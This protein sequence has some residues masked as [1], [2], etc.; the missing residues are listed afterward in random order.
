MPFKN[1]TILVT[2]GTG[3]FGQAFVRK[4]LRDCSPK[5]VIVFSRDEMKQWEM[6]KAFGN[7]PR[8]RFFVGDVR[9]QRRLNRAF[10]GVDCVI[11]AAAMKIVPCAEYNPFECIKTNV[12]GAMNIIDCA[13]D[14]GV[15][16]VV[17][18]ST[19]KACNPVNLYGATKLCSDKLFVAANAYA[20]ARDIRFSVVRYGNVMGSRGSIIPL[21][22]SLAQSGEIPITDERMTRFM[23]T[24][25]QGV[26]LVWFAT[27]NAVGGEI[28]VKKI[29]SMR[30]VDIAKA[31]APSAKIAII[32]IRPGEKL[33]EVMI[34]E[35]DART[36]VEFDDHY[37]ILP[38]ID[39]LDGRFSIYKNAR[40]CT[41][42]FSYSSDKN[43]DWMS[44]D[45]LRTWISENYDNPNARPKPTSAVE[46]PS[47]YLCET[48]I[49]EVLET[50]P[51]ATPE[52]LLARS[53]V[54]HLKHSENSEALDVLQ[55]ILSHTKD[56]APELY[57]A[58]AVAE[59]RLGRSK[60]AY[61]SLVRLLEKHEDH[62]KA[63]KLLAGIGEQLG[64]QHVLDFS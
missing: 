15:K 18:L 38:Q 3:S 26:E 14:H 60:E 21:F 56:A 2:G 5:K 6:A 8:L 23:I 29:P 31:I 61:L 22:R 49:S 41:E 20:G 57:L 47:A 17:A 1:E 40:P 7:D 4:T 30:V 24:L 48:I 11:H 43:T 37:V 50:L 27:Q 16:R 52:F 58:K 42:G 46:N 54:S 13:L 45:A 53:A 34:S 28:Y 62:V 36:T 64:A 39:L 25:E 9:D 32:G 10:D 55:S 51:P 19:D 59:L 33:H 35:E 63:R 44:A 12:E